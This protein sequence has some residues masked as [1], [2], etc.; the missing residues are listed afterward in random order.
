MISAKEMAMSVPPQETDEF[1]R[2]MT[3]IE[4]R[5]GFSSGYYYRPGKIGKD[6]IEKLEQLGFTVIITYYLR[7]GKADHYSTYICWTEEAVE[8][9]KEEYSCHKVGYCTNDPNYVY[10]EIPERYNRRMA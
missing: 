3:S 4:K 2:T 10:E 8:R 9:N 6:T 7:Y 5:K 1:D